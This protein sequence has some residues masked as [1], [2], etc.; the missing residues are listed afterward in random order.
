MSTVQAQGSP[1]TSVAKGSPATPVNSNSSSDP[2]DPS[3]W[4]LSEKCNS[5]D[6][7]TYGSSQHAH[8]GT[9]EWAF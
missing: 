7:R 5:V 3:G 9:A 1:A 8:L 4:V 6:E 2:S